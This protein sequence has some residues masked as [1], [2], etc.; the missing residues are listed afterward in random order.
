MDETKKDAEV[1]R[2][3]SGFAP[4][5]QRVTGAASPPDG[6]PAQKEAD[7]GP[8]RRFIRCEAEAAACDRRLYSAFRGAGALGT[9]V[10]NADRRARRLAAELFI[11]TGQRSS[12]RVSCPPFRDRLTALKDAMDRDG[13]EAESYRTEAQRTLDPQLRE[14]YRTYA[15]ERAAAAAQKRALIRRMF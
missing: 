9:H 1:K 15:D 7:D 11:L 14:L 6:A 12:V 8:L 10:K 5:W 13:G 2:A 3:L 4:V